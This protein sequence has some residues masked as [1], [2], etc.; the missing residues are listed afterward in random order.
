MEAQLPETALLD[1]FSGLV[2]KGE[3]VS[4]VFSPI[5]EKLWAELREPPSFTARKSAP[6]LDRT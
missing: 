1:L 5:S 2:S 3:K 4:P 6:Y